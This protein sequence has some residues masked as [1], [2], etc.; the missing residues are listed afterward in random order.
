MVAVAVAAAE[1][2]V[3]AE[4]VAAAVVAAAAATT[5]PEVAVL[6]EEKADGWAGRRGRAEMTVRRLVAAAMVVVVVVVVVV[7]V[8]DEAAMKA[9][10]RAAATVGGS[11]WR[12]RLRQRETSLRSWP[13]SLPARRR[14]FALALVRLLS[15]PY[16]HLAAR[17]NRPARSHA[18]PLPIY[19]QADQP[20]APRGQQSP[21]VSRV[22]TIDLMRSCMV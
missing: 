18:E 11:G 12:C 21:P 7:M 20:A 10:V 8:G 3:A 19:E 13:R 6:L 22:R 17:P 1:Q 2:A 16:H 5:A 4:A 14:T 9:A 15:S